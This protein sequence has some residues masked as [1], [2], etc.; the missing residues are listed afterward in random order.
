[1][2]KKTTPNPGGWGTSNFL[3]M[4]YDKRSMSSLSKDNIMKGAQKGL[5]IVIVGI[6]VNTIGKYTV[7][8][9]PLP[10]YGLESAIK[11]F[12]AGTVGIIGTEWAQERWMK[13]ST[14]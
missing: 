5:G 7:K 13:K 11:L 4:I 2:V 8:R 14:S 6:V 10:V 9:Q 1:M 3:N 12:V